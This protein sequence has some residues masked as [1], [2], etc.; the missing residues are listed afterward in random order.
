MSFS[1]AELEQKRTT[2]LAQREQILSQY[3]QLSGAIFALDE[4]INQM[5]QE[6]AKNGEE[7]HPGCDKE[8]GCAA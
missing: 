7:I 2:F 3:N 5:K 6:E 8:E 1:V 4:L